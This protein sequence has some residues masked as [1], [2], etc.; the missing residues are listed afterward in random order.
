[1]DKRQQLHNLQ[2]GRREGGW[3]H[4]QLSLPMV[5]LLKI[6]AI[7]KIHIGV[8]AVLSALKRKSSRK[9]HLGEREDKRKKKSKRFLTARVMVTCNRNP[10]G[11][12]LSYFLELR[13]SQ[14]TEGG[15]NNLLKSVTEDQQYNRKATGVLN[16]QALGHK[17]MIQYQS[18]PIW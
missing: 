6:L 15:V 12:F 7:Q 8:S 1:M 13:C 11:K 17:M 3:H 4:T 16:I 2:G 14:T 10:K 9:T 18:Q 5:A